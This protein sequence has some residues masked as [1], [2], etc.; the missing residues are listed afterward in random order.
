MKLIHAVLI[1]ALASA[2]AAA[3][4]LTSPTRTDGLFAPGNVAFL[5]LWLVAENHSAPLG[6]P[7]DSLAGVTIRVSGRAAKLLNVGPAGAVFIV[8]ELPLRA[9]AFRY[10]QGDEV[11]VVTPTASYSLPIRLA[12]TAPGL[13][14]QNGNPIGMIMTTWAEFWFLTGQ[15]VVVPLGRGAAFLQFTVSG[16]LAAGSVELAIGNLRFTA[17]DVSA[18]PMIPGRERATFILPQGTAAGVYE[19]RIAAGRAAS[20]AFTITIIN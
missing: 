20:E 15:P 13:F 8:P 3:Q 6:E 7:A 16:V 4:T 10:R 12:A 14:R 17:H 11:D 18:D 9:G 1:L 5:N 19:C 2:A